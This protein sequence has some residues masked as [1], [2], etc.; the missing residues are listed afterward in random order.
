[1]RAVLEPDIWVAAALLLIIVDL[2]FGLALFVLSIGAA[3]L[4]IAGILFAQAHGWL[5]D[6][7]LIETVRGVAVWFATLSV[8]T[9]TG[10]KLTFR[11]TR[12]QPD[13]NR[14]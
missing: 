2:V 5:G 6:T 1:M 8:A 4:V 11:Q 7:V 10:L 12:K 13:V 3:A 9:V 14:Y